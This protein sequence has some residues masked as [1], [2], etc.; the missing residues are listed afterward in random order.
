MDEEPLFY[1]QS[2]GI[3]RDEATALLVESFAA[4]ALSIVADQPW[5]GM[6]EERVRAWLR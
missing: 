4:E 5:H 2:R 1:M 3:G 6:L